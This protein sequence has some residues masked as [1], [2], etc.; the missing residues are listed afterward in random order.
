[1]TAWILVSHLWGPWVGEIAGSYATRVECLMAGYG[2]VP[3]PVCVQERDFPVVG[4][5]CC[6]QLGSYAVLPPCRDPRSLYLIRPLSAVN[7]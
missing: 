4:A 5:I 7:D 2:H 1:M 6:P 3:Y